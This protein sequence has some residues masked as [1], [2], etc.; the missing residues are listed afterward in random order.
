MISCVVG[1]AASRRAGS[2]ATA[3]AVA[4]LCVCA[5]ALGA[6]EAS[7]SVAEFPS[8][9]TSDGL[10]LHSTLARPRGMAGRMPVALLT[11]RDGGVFRL[12]QGQAEIGREVF[13]IEARAIESTVT[14]PTGGVRIA[15]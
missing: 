10:T 2:S 9:F 6:Q 14:F 15:F 13:R 5:P 3:L 12:Y 8:T 4:L 11:Q 1:F 7:E